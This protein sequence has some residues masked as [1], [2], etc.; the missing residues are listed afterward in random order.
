MKHNGIFIQGTWSWDKYNIL[1][2]T[3][4]EGKTENIAELT[5]DNTDITTRSATKRLIAYAPNMYSL[6]HT[7]SSNLKYSHLSREARKDVYDMLS[8]ID[9]GALT[10][11]SKRLIAYAPALLNFVKAVSEAPIGT[12][13]IRDVQEKAAEL[14]KKIGDD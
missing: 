11:P 6:L 14:V 10:Y 12:N 5:L 7:L 2:A 8:M 4:E 13:V 1:T 9:Y 3:D